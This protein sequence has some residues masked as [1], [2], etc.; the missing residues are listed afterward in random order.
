MNRFQAASPN[1][2]ELRNLIYTRRQCRH[3][4]VLMGLVSAESLYITEI[5]FAL[6]EFLKAAVLSFN[7]N[8]LM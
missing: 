8:L 3:C 5:D 6:K 7:W 1:F 2:C 4:F